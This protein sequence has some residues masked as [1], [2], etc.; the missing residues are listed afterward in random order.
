MIVKAYL[1]SLWM[2]QPVTAVEAANTRAA[3]NALAMAR[4]MNMAGLTS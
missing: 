2:L 4:R 1:V 3:D